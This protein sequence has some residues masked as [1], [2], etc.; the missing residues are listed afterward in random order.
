MSNWKK[1]IVEQLENGIVP[2][3]EDLEEALKG[4]LE[5]NKALR[6]QLETALSERAIFEGMTRGMSDWLARMVFAHL[7]LGVDEL[8]DTLDLFVK[9]RVQMVEKSELGLH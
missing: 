9:K 2:T 3:P 6:Q 8:K 4:A 5:E 7:N 1:N